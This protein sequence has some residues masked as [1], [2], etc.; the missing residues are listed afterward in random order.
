MTTYLII[1]KKKV[2]FRT[3]TF[4]KACNK[5]STILGKETNSQ[6]HT[7]IAVTHTKSTKTD[8]RY[9]DLFKSLGIL[10][11]SKNSFF[12]DV[13][14]TKSTPELY[15]VNKNRLCVLK[16]LVTILDGMPK[17]RIQSF[18]EEYGEINLDYLCKEIEDTVINNKPLMKKES[19]INEQGEIKREPDEVQFYNNIFT[20]FFY[21]LYIF[22]N[23]DD[24]KEQLK[25][26]YIYDIVP[27][28]RYSFLNINEGSVEQTYNSNQP[29]MFV[30]LLPSYTVCHFWNTLPITCILNKPSFLESK[31]EDDMIYQLTLDEIKSLRDIDIPDIFSACFE[32]MHPFFLNEIAIKDSELIKVIKDDNTNNSLHKIMTAFAV[33]SYNHSSMIREIHRLDKELRKKG[34]KH[35]IRLKVHAEYRNEYGKECLVLWIS[36]RQ[37][38]SFA[39]ECKEKRKSVL[40]T[41]WG[42]CDSYDIHS[43]NFNIVKLFNK[44]KFNANW[45]LKKKILSLGIKK[46]RYGDS[47]VPITKNDLGVLPYVIF[48]YKGDNC[49]QMLWGAIEA[50]YKK[51][52]TDIYHPI[53]IPFLT[54]WGIEHIVQLIQEECGN[55]DRFTNCVFFIES[56]LELR[57]IYTMVIN[58]YAIENV[59][60]E[61]FFNPK[62]ISNKE[63]KKLVKDTFEKFYAEQVLEYPELKEI[64]HRTSGS[65]DDERRMLNYILYHF[66]YHRREN[67]LFFKNECSIKIKNKYGKYEDV[68]LSKK[69][70]LRLRRRIRQSCTGITLEKDGEYYS[71]KIDWCD[72]NSF[73]DKCISKGIIEESDV[74]QTM[75]TILENIQV[76]SNTESSNNAWMINSSFY[77]ND[78]IGE[79]VF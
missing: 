73:L 20:K 22:C 49:F 19:I 63:F 26:S 56:I 10:E 74:Q 3:G 75:D 9:R 4:L 23:K 54:K 17:R 8:Y 35:L 77:I 68:S 36:L 61:F 25:N 38:S 43:C 34:I 42:S 46:K 27:L 31:A 18:R 14:K 13:D 1:N 48:N 50:E 53:E 47:F 65:I 69:D 70:T 78:E 15:C 57:I 7:K 32:Q 60:D 24:I 21:N 58:N 64:S 44:G 40:K 41:N 55:W 76:Y 52:E 2:S 59:N 62:Q 45:N 5:L 11:L 12:N 33:Y 51:R 28:F 71:Y 37:S 29:Y 6:Y 39:K 16:A 79:D 30:H 66:K 67:T 72:F